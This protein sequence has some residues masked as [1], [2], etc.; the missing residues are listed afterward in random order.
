MTILT[1]LDVVAAVSATPIRSPGHD[2]A[3]W[4]SERLNMFVEYGDVEGKMG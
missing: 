2:Y 3:L 4:L 1:G